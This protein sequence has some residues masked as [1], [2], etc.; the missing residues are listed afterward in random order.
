MLR[1]LGIV[2]SGWVLLFG[3]LYLCFLVFDIE[4]ILYFDISLGLVVAIVVLCYAAL[5]L[6][7]CVCFCD[8]CC[9]MCGLL[10]V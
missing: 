3:G 6:W 8:I 9:C 7:C 10:F 4:V 2:R 1:L 5:I